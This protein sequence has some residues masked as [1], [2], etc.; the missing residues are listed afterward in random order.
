MAFEGLPRPEGLEDILP[1][2]GPKE[3]LEGDGRFANVEGSHGVGASLSDELNIY[4]EIDR[5]LKAAGRA[6][7]SQP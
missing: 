2:K 1:K 4:R 3:A 6:G 7:F 5:A